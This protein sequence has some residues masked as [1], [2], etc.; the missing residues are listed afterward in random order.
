MRLHV[1]RKSELALRAIRELATREGA[2]K[3]AALAASIDTTPA[4]L[5]QT[6]ASLVRADHLRSE[7]GPNGGYRLLATGRRLSVRDVIELIEGPTRVDRCVLRE[8]PCAATGQGSP[9][10]LHDAWSVARTSL[11]RELGVMPVID[12]TEL[13]SRAGGPR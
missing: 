8:S 5:A 3:G 9:C 1:T 13:G 2:T 11:L 4:F 7:P 10:A 6:L 12:H